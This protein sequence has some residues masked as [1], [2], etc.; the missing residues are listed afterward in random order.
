MAVRAVAGCDEWEDKITMHTGHLDGEVMATSLVDKVVF[1]QE[2][3]PRDNG[4]SHLSRF[5]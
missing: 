5:W 1:A 2:T 3:S 4:Q